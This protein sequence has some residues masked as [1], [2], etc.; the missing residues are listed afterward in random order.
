MVGSNKEVLLYC[1]FYLNNSFTRKIFFV[2]IQRKLKAEGLSVEL[3]IERDIVHCGGN[4]KGSFSVIYLVD[5]LFIHS[6]H[7]CLLPKY[8]ISPYLNMS[9]KDVFLIAFLS[10]LAICFCVLISC[11][12]ITVGMI[13]QMQW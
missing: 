6:F 3:L 13:T 8:A 12:L 1:L 11:T 4:L 2:K 9:L 5:V 10:K 7:K